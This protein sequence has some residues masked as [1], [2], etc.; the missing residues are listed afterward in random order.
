MTTVTMRTGGSDRGQAKREIE[1]G[2]SGKMG[3]TF[4][5]RIGQPPRTSHVGTRAPVELSAS[6]EL[7]ASMREPGRWQRAK[8]TFRPLR[9]GSVGG[10]QV[11]YGKNMR[12]EDAEMA[13]ALNCLTQLDPGWSPVCTLNGLSLIHI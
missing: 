7:G 2:K 4:S 3:N 9:M 1:L 10:R 8:R 6:E 13:K 11:T 5:G 12:K